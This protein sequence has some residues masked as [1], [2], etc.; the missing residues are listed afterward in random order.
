M[1]LILTIITFLALTLSAKSQTQ[2][3]WVDSVKVPVTDT[4]IT[5]L[6]V[7]SAYLPYSYKGEL[8]FHYVKK[9]KQ[10]DVAAY[11]W[12]CE[13]DLSR[14]DSSIAVNLGGGNSL[15]RKSPRLYSY[16]AVTTD[17]LTLSRL[18]YKKTVNGVA[19]NKYALVGTTAFR[20][21][22]PS[23]YI[24]RKGATAGKYIPF[25]FRFFK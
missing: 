3:A 21:Q 12:A 16:I 24:K 19:Q 25:V 13:F 1:K 7:D 5:F 15:I 10:V 17:T 14:L 20:Y 11:Q 22:Y 8:L 6:G 2:I 4:V 23:I 9:D 18:K